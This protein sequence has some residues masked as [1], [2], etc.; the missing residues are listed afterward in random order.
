MKV[1]MK[2][3][4]IEAFSTEEAKQK[5]L[6][7]GLNVVR[8]VTNSWKA[9]DCPDC[10]SEDFKQFAETQFEKHKMTDTTGIGFIVVVES[11]TKDTRKF[12]YEFVDNK[13]KG[14]IEKKRL[15]EIRLAES[16]KLIG[17]AETKGDAIRTAKELMC[18]YKQDMIT[19][20]VYRVLGDKGVAF[21][22]N[23]APSQNTTK[24]KYVVFGN[25]NDSF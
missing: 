13:V 2:K 16:D 1:N 20:V 14:Q 7:M 15:F 24:G 10:N 23:Y 19:K 4:I 9:N 11:G 5:A 17:E 21:K 8:N 22:L 25:L 12:P 6:N 3:F 18:K